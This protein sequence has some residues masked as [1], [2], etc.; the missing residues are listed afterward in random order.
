MSSSANPSLEVPSKALQRILSDLARED[1]RTS[2]LY[3]R[4]RNFERK[5][6]ALKVSVAPLVD[7]RLILQHEQVVWARNLSR[8]GIS[9]VSE[10]PL[11]VKEIG[12]RLPNA[13][14]GIVWMQG[15]VMRERPIQEGFWEFGVRFIGAIKV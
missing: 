8:S 5:T 1:Q 6:I 11:G 9:F 14:A 13:E 12:V 7:G 3:G 2:Q 10:A 4:N 15:N